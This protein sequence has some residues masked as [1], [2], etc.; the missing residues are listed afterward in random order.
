VVLEVLMLDASNVVKHRRLLMG[1]LGTRHLFREGCC[2][3]SML[4][5]RGRL[6]GEEN[7]LRGTLGRMLLELLM[8]HSRLNFIMTLYCIGD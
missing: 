4:D 3:T 1:K 2:A 7:A 6:L 8:I 5:A